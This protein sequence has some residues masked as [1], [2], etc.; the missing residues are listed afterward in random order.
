MKFIMCLLL[1]CFIAG[2]DLA[3]QPPNRRRAPTPPAPHVKVLAFTATWCGPCQRA[4]PILE[5][6]KGLGFDVEFVDIDQ[7]PEMAKHYGVQSIPTIFIFN[8]DV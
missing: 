6:I 8:G 5:E 3:P 1:F 7:N 2:C 4:H